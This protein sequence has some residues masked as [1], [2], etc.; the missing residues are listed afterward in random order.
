[1]P[2][3]V[4][5]EKAPVVSNEKDMQAFLAGEAVINDEGNLVRKE[6]VE[7]RAENNAENKSENAE[8][9]IEDIV[10]G[11]EILKLPKAQAEKVKSAIN[12][13][14]QDLNRRDGERGSLLEQ[15]N[16]RLAKLEGGNGKAVPD[17]DEGLPPLPARPDRKLLLT[18]PE[19]YENQRDTYQETLTKREAARV[20]R[21]IER[22]NELERVQKEKQDKEIRLVEGKKRLESA[23]FQTFPLLKDKDVLVRESL[24]RHIEQWK[25]QGVETQI[26]VGQCFDAVA[27]DVLG[28]LKQWGLSVADSKSK[29]KKGRQ[30]DAEGLDIF[31]AEGSQSVRSA[32]GRDTDEG[33]EPPRSIAEAI[34]ARRQ[35][36]E[37][38]RG[39]VLLRATKGK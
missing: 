26:S 5:E 19:E 4:A 23:F 34:K 16:S 2:D 29:N 24:N 13:Y 18:D 36:T 6:K 14:R 15:I 32:S 10:L 37:N 12:S 35:A 1:M 20:L 38:R 9:E 17:E 25:E 28:R 27:K 30:S 33:E 31:D 39:R 21:E 11:T 7:K 3:A 22:K 8:N